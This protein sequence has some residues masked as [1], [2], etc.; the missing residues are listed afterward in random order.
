MDTFDLFASSLVSSKKYVFKI[1]KYMISL[2]S[3]LNV[4][5]AGNTGMQPD[6]ETEPPAR[7]LVS[8]TY[9]ELDI[10]GRK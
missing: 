10:T 2:K 6:L 1:G 7:G 4:T 5:V 8:P 3:W 9:I